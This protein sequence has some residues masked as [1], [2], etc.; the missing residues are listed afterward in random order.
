MGKKRILA[1]IYAA[2]GVLSLGLAKSKVSV[3]QPYPE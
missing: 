1:Y 2:T 3:S